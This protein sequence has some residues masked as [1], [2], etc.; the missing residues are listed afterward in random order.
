MEDTK[1]K[2]KAEK[3]VMATPRRLRKIGGSLAL[4]IPYEYV[5]ANHLKPGQQVVVAW[6]GSNLKIV[7]PD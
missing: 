2:L 7:L 6:S 3:T 4:A 1:V 5:K